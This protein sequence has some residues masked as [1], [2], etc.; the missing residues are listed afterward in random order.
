[1]D[2]HMS[3]G[4][5]LYTQEDLDKAVREAKYDVYADVFELF[6]KKRGH[7]GNMLSHNWQITGITF[8]AR[9]WFT[10]G[11]PSTQSWESDLPPT[12]CGEKR[13]YQLSK[14]PAES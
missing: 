1:M 5:K 8:T 2:N 10:R 11:T 3:T 12:P 13:P 7:I 6:P 14:E 9:P 4:E